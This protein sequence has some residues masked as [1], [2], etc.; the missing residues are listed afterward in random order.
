[1]KKVNFDSLS[2]INTPQEWLK[3]AGGIPVAY[4][5]PKSVKRFKP[6]HVA[7][8]ASMVMVS[9]ITAA[10]W[11]L[12]G[13]GSGAPIITKSGETIV[14]GSPVSPT[15][16]DGETGDLS[17]DSRAEGMTVPSE[18]SDDTT[19]AVRPMNPFASS[20]P[21][22]KSPEHTDTPT[23][24]EPNTESKDDPTKP[25]MQDGTEPDITEGPTVPTDIAQ[26]TA[27]TDPSNV[28]TEAVPT[29]DPTDHDIPPGD[30]EFYAMI[31]PKTSVT[32]GYNT[33]EDMSLFCRIYDSDGHM[34]GDSDLLSPQ[35]E[36]TILSLFSDG[37]VYAYYNPTHKGLY[38]TEG[39]YEYVFYDV[40]NNELYRDIKFVF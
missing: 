31:S 37:T 28:P 39:V 35:R 33:A 36:A 18:H 22:L 7:A 30:C 26:P 9:V 3:K 25:T 11:L 24:T 34:V 16:T 10:V 17:S 5:K 15:M 6:R 2:H 4:E 23:V 21:E 27:S 12:F 29:Q 38:I 1:M 19:A 20:A 40:H 13:D 32:G 14:T 8:A